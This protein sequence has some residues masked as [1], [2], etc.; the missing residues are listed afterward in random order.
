MKNIIRNST[1]IYSVLFVLTLFTSCK[2]DEIIKDNEYGH[3]QFKICKLVGARSA[4]AGKALNDPLESLADI[5]K[6]K[7]YLLYNNQDISQ[8][9]NVSYFNGESADFGVRTELLKLA[10]G[11]YTLKGY[12]IYKSDSNGV[13][14]QNV[15]LDEGVDFEITGGGNTVVDV[16]VNSNLKG[17]LSF[18]LG[19]DFSLIQTKAGQVH[20][21]DK[22]T[23]GVSFSYENI[24]SLTVHFS[25]KGKDVSYQFNVSNT[26]KNG[27][28][29]FFTDT[30][31]IAAG[32]YTVTG[33][34][35]NSKKDLQGSTILAVVAEDENNGIKRLHIEDNVL[36]CDT[37]EM[38]LPKTEAIKDYLA[39]YDIWNAMKGPTWSYTGSGEPAEANWKFKGRTIDTW[40]NQPG[41]GLD[42]NGRVASLNLGAFNAKG[43]LPDAIGQLTQIKM[44]YLGTHSEE[45]GVDPYLLYKKGVDLAVNRMDIAREA[46]R[47]SHAKRKSELMEG[48][49]VST[50]SQSNEKPYSY[51]Y[52]STYDAVA[53]VHTNGITGIS[54]EIAKLVN[55]TH[56]FIA[57]GLITELPQALGELPSLTDL[58]I[59]NCPL[60]KFPDQLGNLENLISLNFSMNIKIPAKEMERGLRKFFDGKSKEKIQILFLN[61]QGLESIPENMNNLKKLGSLD[62]RSNKLTSLPSM[63]D[64]APVFL[65]LDDNQLTSIPDDLCNI[66]DFETFSA[67]NNKIE[68][69]P[70]LFAADNLYLATLIDFSVN[71][72]SR[73]SKNFK[74]FRTETL[75][76]T[77]NRFDLNKAANGRVILPDEFGY[78][79][80]GTVGSFKGK[81]VTNVVNSLKMSTCG[82]DSISPQSIENLTSVMAWELTGNNLKYLP[83]YFSAEAFPYLSGLDLSYNAFP[84]IPVGVLNIG[85]LNQLYFNHQFDHETGKRTMNKIQGNIYKHL[86]LRILRLAGNNILSIGTFPSVLNVLD[87]SDNPNLLMEIPTEI[88]DRIKIGSFLLGFDETQSGITGCP[89]L[90]IK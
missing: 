45:T 87:V 11:T 53:G 66:N 82:I 37:V 57:N 12:E 14:A 58:E 46:V 70:A 24:R 85:G 67:I 65:Y 16:D 54:E 55:M 74:G 88:C 38:L 21:P 68:E 33:Y 15:S 42:G 56:L 27:R 71:R 63:P 29:L 20:D 44:L 28:D 72:I 35:A 59:Y 31:K 80:I 36:V 13:P 60:T 41:V 34:E 84:D 86:S 25:Y 75:D 17:R 6:I 19:K 26:K 81:K 62:L 4:V 73:F 43:F 30:L 1:W 10:T 23:E 76:L 8:T 69:F 40:G 2:D 51:K 49:I 79:A 48:K 77:Y 7:V 22:E 89:I 50:L 83:S 78:H 52:I 39:L 3:V 5:Q 32:D 61:E 64:V 18:V 9:L 90:D 47:Y